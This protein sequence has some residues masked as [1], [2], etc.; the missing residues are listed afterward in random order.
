M[1][2]LVQS[3]KMKIER[4]K[5]LYQQYLL[6]RLTDI[7]REEWMTLLEDKY[8]RPELE[9]AIPWFDISAHNLIGLPEPTANRIINQIVAEPQSR[10]AKTK[11]WPYI[12]IAA[13]FALLI[14]SVG[15][16]FINQKQSKIASSIYA[17]DIAPGRE[18]ATLTLSNGKQIKL[19]EAGKGEIAKEAGISIRKMANGQVDY[20]ISSLNEGALRPSTNT[21]TTAKGE[22]YRI[23]L[24]DGTLV[25]LNAASSLTYSSS[26]NDQRER[27]VILS[28]EAYFEVFKNKKRPFI[29][30][31][32]RQEVEVVGTHFNVSAYNDDQ[33]IKTTLLEGI[34]KVR[35]NKSNQLLKPGQESELTR[36]GLL[37]I[38]EVDTDE[39]VA[40]KDGYFMF[41]NED[42]E[43]IMLKLSRWYNVDIEFQNEDIKTETFGGTMNRFAN[44]SAALK[45]LEMTG[46][47]H[48]NIEGRRIKIRK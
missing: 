7:E 46:K 6:K 9:N 8:L 16:F 47:V 48:F 37:K 15:Y 13:S 23:H 12:A 34:V 19:S 44:I 28:G 5:Y 33:T 2:L 17:F 39:A 26:L 1:L 41:N 29:V 43:S 32:S 30:K 42:L 4:F 24:P 22:T 40:W 20:N 3:A 18:G 31:T 45:I 11:L 36:S 38:E 21:L 14:V 35:T 25:T 27:K 10:M